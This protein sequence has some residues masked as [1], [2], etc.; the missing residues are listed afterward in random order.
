MHGKETNVAYYECVAVAVAI[1]YAKIILRI[2][3][4]CVPLLVV[5]HSPHNHIKEAIFEKRFL[6]QKMSVFVFSTMISFGSNSCTTIL[7]Y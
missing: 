7:L 3:L 6:E 1:K 5:P 2:I 4:I